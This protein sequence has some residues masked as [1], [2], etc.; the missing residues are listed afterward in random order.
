[1]IHFILEILF[2]LCCGWIGRWTVKLLTFG[3]VDLHHSDTDDSSIA[4]WIGVIV[5]VLLLIGTVAI[6]RHA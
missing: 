5:V 2:E 6:V 1:M 3:K 4:E